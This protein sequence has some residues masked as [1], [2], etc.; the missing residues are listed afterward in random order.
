MYRKIDP[1]RLRLESEFVYF[2]KKVRL[3]LIFLLF[4]ETIIDWVAT[5]FCSLV[6]NQRYLNPALDFIFY[7]IGLDWSG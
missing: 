7:T 5:E 3:F 6:S 1:I 4:T 2:S